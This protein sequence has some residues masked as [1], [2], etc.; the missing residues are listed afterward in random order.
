[1]SLK[2]CPDE[3]WQL[4]GGDVNPSCSSAKKWFAN[5]GKDIEVLRKIIEKGKS[6]E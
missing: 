3:A 2:R 5:C 1:M 4:K 6:K